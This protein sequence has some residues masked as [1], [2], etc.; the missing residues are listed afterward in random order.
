MTSWV[1]EGGSN[2]EVTEEDLIIGSDS[3]FS[4]APNHKELVVDHSPEGSICCGVR[5][6]SVQFKDLVVS[7]GEYET[8]M[9]HC[10][11]LGV[12]ARVVGGQVHIVDGLDHTD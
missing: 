12:F 3:D 10:L 7:E 4:I 9:D 11:A 2:A 1:K 6:R 5:G 8:W